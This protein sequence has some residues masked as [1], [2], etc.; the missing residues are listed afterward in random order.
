MDGFT[1]AL[2]IGAALLAGGLNA[3]AGGG[4]FLTFPA[5]VAAGLPPIVANASSTVATSPG[6]FASAFAYRRDFVPLPIVGFRPMLAASIIG[7]F[8]GAVLLLSTPAAAFDLLVPW[9]LL[10]ATILFWFGP[11]LAPLVARHVRIGPVGLL[12][13]QLLAGIYGGYFGGAV[14]IMMLA[15]YGLF[16][17]DD[18]R[19]MNAVKTL[20]VGSMN[21]AAVICFI[22]AGKVD[23]PPTLAM[24]V[25][26]VTGGYVGTRLARR[27]NRTVLRLVVTLVGLAM[28]TAFFLR[29]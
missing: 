27:I 3:V 19:M 21:A 8:A 4:S 18:V 14:G 11:R 15:I 5:L 9:L 13:L 6:S 1:W 25:A 28:T 22:A 2:L 23:W 7:G 26:A 24:L 29:A 20:L 12:A 10:I 16:G 17:L